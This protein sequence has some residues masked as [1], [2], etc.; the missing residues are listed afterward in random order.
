M[1]EAIFAP[2]KHKSFKY[3]MFS[4]MLDEWYGAD[5]NG[6]AECDVIEGYDDPRVCK[7]S[8]AGCC[9]FH[10]LRDTRFDRGPCRYEVCPV[11]PKL[12]ERYLADHKGT[13]TSYD[14]DLYNMLSGMIRDIDRRVGVSKNKRES[15]AAELQIHPEI[16]EFDIKIND[17]LKKSY[18]LGKNGDVN[19]AVN[20][21]NE[22]DI[23]RQ[24]RK[25]KEQ[26]LMK[27]T[28]DKYQKV[29]ICEVCSAVIQNSDL[30]G[31]MEEHNVG[32]Q[33]V[34]YLKMREV[35]ETLKSAG[36]ASN[37]NRRVSVYNQKPEENKKVAS[38]L[39]RRLTPLE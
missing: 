15:Q 20:T 30:D 17:L 38:N 7:L 34:A 5:R 14:Q 9:P 28:F 29:R 19:K 6:N 27:T 11:P 21:L 22:A 8:L 37:K 18:E 4:K 24:K 3:G 12:R 33:H 2:R 1:S 36:L 16:K 31:R 13:T 35:F 25:I 26:E 10:L 39:I 32:R 23:L